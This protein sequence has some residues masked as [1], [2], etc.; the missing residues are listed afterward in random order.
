MIKYTPQNQ[1]RLELFKHPF[2]QELDKSNR[3]VIWASLLP[4][5]DMAEVYCRQLHSDSGRKTVDVRTVLAALFVKHI[6]DL[7]DRGTIQMIQENI[8]L[9]YFCGLLGFT[10]AP[11]FD[12]S[13]FVDIRKRMGDE[14]F[15]IL[16]RLLVNE[17][18][19]LKHHQARIKRKGKKDQKDD[20]NHGEQEEHPPNRGILKVDASIADQQIKFPTDEGLLSIGREN[21]ERIIDVLYEPQ[22]D[23]TKPRTYRRIARKKHLE[24]SKKKR[25]GVKQVRKAI[26]AQLQF[27]RRDLDIIDMLLNDPVKRTPL[28]KRDRELLASIRQVYQQQKWMYENKT[29]SCA[30]RIVNIFQSQVR[31][32]V[33]GKDRNYTEFGSKIN[34]S[35]V[36]G[37]CFIDK[38]SW[39]A[40][41]EGTNLLEQVENF[42]QRYGC[43]PKLLLADGIYLKRE[44]RKYLKSKD[45]EIVGKPLGRPSKV[46]KESASKKYYKKKKAAKRNHVE[47][48]FGQGKRSF[49]LN[50]IKARLPE[51][52]ESWVNAIFFAMNMVKLLQLALKQSGFLWQFLKSGFLM[53][54]KEFFTKYQMRNSNFAHQC[55]A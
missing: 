15:E 18:E 49:G 37:F 55:A 10:T 26:K 31:P 51:T 9:Q 7:D 50:N 20:N 24:F 5:N 29:N 41:N 30:D 45:I 21:L 44:N 39:D 14:S 6:L 43:Y 34:I 53:V 28:S 35:E 19:K 54:F 46:S 33:R 23:K 42:Y 47:G 8:Y 32:M 17:S 4:W 48:K 40:F 22:T 12:P 36:N 11:V 38:L 1:I 25:K 13:L 52:S 2:E 27:V 16:N 3:W